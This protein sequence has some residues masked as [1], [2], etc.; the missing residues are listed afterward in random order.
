VQLIE[1]HKIGGAIDCHFDVS[2]PGL[3]IEWYWLEDPVVEQGSKNGTFQSAIQSAP[4]NGVQCIKFW[5]EKVRRRHLYQ[6]WR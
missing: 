2:D 6:L 5:W 4:S 1:Q 3:G